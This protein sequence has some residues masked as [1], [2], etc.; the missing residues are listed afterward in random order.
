MSQRSSSPSST[1]SAANVIEHHNLAVDEHPRVTQETSLPDNRVLGES[2]Q[3][4][5]E[6]REHSGDL[7]EHDS[8]EY[9][10][11]DD[12]DDDIDEEEEEPVLKYEQLGG[13]AQ[14]ILDKDSASALAVSSRFM[15]CILT[16]LWRLSSD[17]VS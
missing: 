4:N 6:D 2:G 8:E 9:E 16:L 3:V 14:D 13:G 10:S 5:G 12:D 7:D 17:C 1:S 15:V 11:D